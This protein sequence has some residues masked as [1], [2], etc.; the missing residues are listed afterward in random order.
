M[1]PGTEDAGPRRHRRWPQIAYPVSAILMA[2]ALALAL[3]SAGAAEAATPGSLDSSF[4]SGGVAAFGAGSQLF[5]V[6]VQSDGRVVAAGQSGGKVLV[7]RFATGGQP[8]GVYVGP[9]GY[10]RAVA[11]ESDG[12]IAVAGQTGKAMLVERLTAG[13]T[14]DS[15]FG[16]G[17]IATTVLGGTAAVANGVAIGS[18]GSIVAA[19]A[20][21]PRVSGL[22]CHRIRGLGLPG[23]ARVAL[24]CRATC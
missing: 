22:L 24:W 7:E 4:G 2:L 16:A 6:A 5:G 20:V 15:R 21:S 3:A 17:G 9:A 10:A 19:G 12:T 23:S 18:G 11:I 13:L 14:P 1:H 8:D